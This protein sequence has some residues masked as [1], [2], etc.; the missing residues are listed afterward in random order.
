[1]KSLAKNIEQL[2]ELTESLS[3]GPSQD[4]QNVSSLFEM[5]KELIKFLVGQNEEQRELLEE[6]SI[7]EKQLRTSEA[8]YRTVFE[9]S[10]DAIFLMQHEIYMDCNRRALE[11]FGYTKREILSTNPAKF[12]PSMQPNGSMSRR[13]IT[14]RVGE[15]LRGFPQ[16]FKWSYLKKDGTPFDVHVNLDRID[17]NGGDWLIAYLHEFQKRK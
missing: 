9:H 3:S 5:V 7:L 2:K 4:H 16:S 13:E 6:K 11:M 1:M 14:W 17:M 15:T 8:K 10:L 12:S